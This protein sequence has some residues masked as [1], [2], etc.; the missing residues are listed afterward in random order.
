MHM[1]FRDPSRGNRETNRVPLWMSTARRAA[2]S[3]YAASVPCFSSC[4]VAG[5]RVATDVYTSDVSDD[6]SRLMARAAAA[7][8]TTARAVQAYN[9]LHPWSVVVY[10][11]LALSGSSNI[12]DT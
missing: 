9:A 1:Q 4:D 3:Y 10:K 12:P 5:S 2:A 7:K 11:E 6:P 8:V